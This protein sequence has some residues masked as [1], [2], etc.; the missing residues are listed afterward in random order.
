VPPPAAPFPAPDLLL[1]LQG[2]ALRPAWACAAG[3]ACLAWLLPL[4]APAAAAF[5]PCCCFLAGWLSSDIRCCMASNK[6]YWAS[7]AAAS[8]IT[9]HSNW[10]GEILMCCRLGISRREDFWNR[11]CLCLCWCKGGSQNFCVGI[12]QVSSP[13]EQGG[14]VHY[15]Q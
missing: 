10:L 9:V 11:V 15:V 5:V 7:K 14:L 4:L 2:V 13:F 3:G 12:V 1:A 6:A 8:A